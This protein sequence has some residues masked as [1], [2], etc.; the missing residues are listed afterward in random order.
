MGTTIGGNKLANYS[1]KEDAIQEFK[2]LYLDKTGNE[3]DDR[4]TATKKANKFYPLDMDYG[5][6]VCF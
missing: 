3:W 4:K 6:N 1:K 2:A 5:E